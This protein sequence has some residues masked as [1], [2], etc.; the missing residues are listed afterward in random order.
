MIAKARD[1]STAPGAFA[2]DQFH[3]QDAAA[4]YAPLAEELWEQSGRSLEAFVQ[5][6]GTAQCLRG[7]A[8]ALR[9]L[10]PLVHIVAVE[11]AE[12]QVLAGGVAGP[13]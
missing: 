9:P 1:L 2:A 7:V 3:N 8:G 11:P 5:S 13:H 12:S 6:V 4:G 10:C